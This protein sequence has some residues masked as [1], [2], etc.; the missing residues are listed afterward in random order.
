[1]ARG[2]SALLI[3]TLLLI[4]LGIGAEIAALIGPV[5]YVNKWTSEIIGLQKRCFRAISGERICWTRQ[6]FS[7]RQNPDNYDQSYS[8]FLN[9]NITDD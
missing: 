9:I 7:F 5:W 4:F 8:E 2:Q 1:M 3:I 6:L